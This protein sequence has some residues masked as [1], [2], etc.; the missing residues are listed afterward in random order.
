M[1]EMILIWLV[2]PLVL[3]LLCFGLGLLLKVFIKKPTNIPIITASG[4]L[5]LIIIGSLMTSSGRTTPYTAYL[6]AL[7]SGMGLIYGLVFRRSSIEFDYLPIVGGLITFV[8][9]G[10][11]VMAYGRPSWAGWV[12][13]DD[14]A[15]FLAVTDR[16][17]KAGQSVPGIVNSTFDRIIQV[18][19]GG[20][21]LNYGSV[22]NTHFVYPIGTF[23]PFGVLS[24]VTTLEKAWLFQPYLSF[25]A[26]L[27]AMLCMSILAKQIRGRFVLLVATCVAM[28][29]STI[30]S[31]VMWGGIKEIIIIVPIALMALTLFGDSP[32]VRGRDR[33]LY[34]ALCSAALYFIGGLASFGFAAVLMLVWLLVHA[35]RKSQVHFFAIPTF[36][37]LAILGLWVAY[38]VTGRN[39]VGDLLVPKIKDS[40]NL[41][42]PLKIAQMLGI[43][44]SQDFRL[45]P[46]YK[47]ATFLLILLAFIFAVAGVYLSLKSSFWIIPSLVIA[48]IAVA[49]YAI[50]FGGVWL[51]GKAIAVASPIMLLAVA[52]GLYQVWELSNST[53]RK[54][55]QDFHVRYLIIG[56]AVIIGSGV[57]ISDAFTYKNVWLAPYSQT[58]EL[59]QIGTTF[60]GQGPTLMTE[61]SVFGARYFLRNTGAESA[62]ELRVHPILMSDGTQVP[63]GFSADIGLF[64]SATINNYNLLVLR[65]SPVASRP[66]LNYELAWSGSHYE[67]WRKLANAP[68]IKSMLPLGN[69]F[70][71]GSIPACQDVTNFLSK[72]AKGDKIFSVV[73]NKTYLVSFSNGDLPSTW[74]PTSTSIGAVDRTGPGGFSR[75]FSVDE[76]GFYDL[77]LAGSFPGKLSLLIDGDQIYSGHS[78]FEGNPTL[79]NTLTK[80]HISAGQHVLTLI[81]TSPILMSGSDVSYRFGPIFLS[82]QFAG[83][84][85]AKQVSISRIPQLCTENLDWIAI[86]N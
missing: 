77:S 73:R 53:D 12:Q 60:A 72:R 56:I 68:T 59:R 9:F 4:F 15:S 27:A 24:K 17:M 70:T 45:D 64:D 14:T 1:T 39:L 81:Y 43:W 74:I 29:A 40:G 13:L 30:F 2:A 80:V 20:G 6:I 23:V 61:Y 34:A 51:A 46:V 49:A 10:L 5:L 18:L 31:Y 28:M 69:N 55:F 71:P 26:G 54:F 66:P 3:F 16:I 83:D 78:L 11:P 42:R 48:V 25:A 58:E 65:K 44:P 21:G 32:G 47:P 85:K 37:L 67:V 84:A 76:T 22:T 7:L 63:K 19:L 75:T 36:I 86:A 62:S 33:W 8:V 82:T 57:L 50:I 41:M 52:A 38:R 35:K 79:T